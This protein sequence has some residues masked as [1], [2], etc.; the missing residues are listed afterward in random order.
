MMCPLLSMLSM[1]V[2][3]R[4]IVMQLLWCPEW[5][6]VLLRCPGWLLIAPIFQ[7]LLHFKPIFVIR[8]I[9]RHVNFVNIIKPLFNKLQNLITNHP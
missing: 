2:G 9:I 7:M 1:M 4:V 3:C 5:L 8:F 6:L